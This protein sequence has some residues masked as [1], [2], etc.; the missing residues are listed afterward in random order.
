M[1]LKKTSENHGCL[2]N[3]YAIFK[4]NYFTVRSFAIEHYWKM[5]ERMMMILCN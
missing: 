2:K 3:I 4:I 5:M 1:S